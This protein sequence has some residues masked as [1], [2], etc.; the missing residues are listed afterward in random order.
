MS[1]F[2]SWVPRPA[3]P[4]ISSA[5]LVPFACQHQ[6]HLPPKASLV[7][8]YLT[9]TGSTELPQAFCSLLSVQSGEP[10]ANL[11]W[12]HSRTHANSC[13]ES[14]WSKLRTLGCPLPPYEGCHVNPSR[15]L[16]IELVG[17]IQAERG[18]G[19]ASNLCL[20]SQWPKAPAEHAA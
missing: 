16:R 15:R 9:A 8:F 3:Q 19:L 2:L 12:L 5:P 11:S 20:A 1:P 13:H 14:T 7:D 10:D 18:I 17:N 6:L 4:L